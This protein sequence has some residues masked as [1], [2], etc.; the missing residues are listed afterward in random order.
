MTLQTRRLTPSNSYPQGK[1]MRR[2][3]CALLAALAVIGCGSIASAA[4]MP[5]KAP[6]LWAAPATGPLWEGIYVGVNG[7][8][9]WGRSSWCTDNIVTNCAAGPATDVMHASAN[10]AVGG[11]QFGDRWQTGNIVYG[12]EGMLDGMN[13]SKTNADP[14]F[15][16][17]TLT[18]KFTGVMSATGQAGL[19]FDRLLMYGKSGWAMTELK[20]KAND[21]GAT[22]TGPTKYADGWTVGG[23]L[24][25]Q[26]MP[27]II[28]G[29]EYDYYRFSPGNITNVTNAAGTTISCAFCNFGSSTNLQT[30]LARLSI[31]AGPA[32]TF[33]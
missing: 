19:A 24:E 13:I 18:T 9:A 20:L 16:A 12:F 21:A 17:Q 25:Y 8:E 11:A 22:L 32:P 3:Q 5:V 4:D 26:V 27:H 28:V 1:I 29:V 30:V 7:G 33:R 15:A 14:L 10:G 2:I 31:Q 6:P 23:G